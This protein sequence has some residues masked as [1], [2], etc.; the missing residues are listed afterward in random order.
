MV[1]AF[2]SAMFEHSYQGNYRG[3]YPIKVNQQR[4]LIEDLVRFSKPHHLGLEA[5][6]KPE[7]MVVLAMLE[8]PEAL[9]I[10]N[11]YKDREY[12]DMA[13]D[14]G[15]RHLYIIPMLRRYEAAYELVGYIRDRE[16]TLP[17]PD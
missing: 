14:A 2:E 4:H 8:D 5:G 6:S 13:L 10:C 15:F 17:C 11:G 7:L 12:V 16:G 3:V 1:T 9:I